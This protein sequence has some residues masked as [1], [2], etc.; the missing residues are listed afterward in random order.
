MFTRLLLGEGRGQVERRH[1]RTRGRVRRLAGVNRP[2]LEPEHTFVV[3]HSLLRQLRLARPLTRNDHPLHG[4]ALAAIVVHRIVLHTA[5]VPDCEGSG[6]PIET[7]ADLRAPRQFAQEIQERE[8]LVAG[9][10]FEL[11]RVRQARIDRFAARLGV[12]TDKRVLGRRTPCKV[13]RVTSRGSQ[14]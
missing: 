14:A 7:R 1:H 8:A 6:L 9:E 2:G 11:A 13:L 3:R 10:P 12:R 5:I 4:P